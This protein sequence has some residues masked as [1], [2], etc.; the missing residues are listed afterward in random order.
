MLLASEQTTFR[1]ENGGDRWRP[2]TRSPGIRYAW[3]APDALYRADAAG[4]VSVSA[5]GA[6]SWRPVGRVQGEPAR[7]KALDAEHLYVV[8]KTGAILESRDGAKNWKPVYRP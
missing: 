6:D 8:L 5:D 3:P 1:S 2:L 7:L 4:T